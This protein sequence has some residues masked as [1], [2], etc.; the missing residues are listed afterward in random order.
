MMRVIAIIAGILRLAAAAGI[1]MRYLRRAEGIQPADWQVVEATITD[2]NSD[3]II[4]YT[5]IEVDGGRRLSLDKGFQSPDQREQT[6]AKLEAARAGGQSLRF[7]VYTP[8]PYASGE[9]TSEALLGI[10]QI[11]NDEVIVDPERSAE[12]LLETRG[13][14]LIYAILAGLSGLIVIWRGVQG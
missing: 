11:D 12:I 10:T 5:L 6:A 13:Q 2:L 14:V 1:G 7:T 4:N 9:R 8:P 3:P